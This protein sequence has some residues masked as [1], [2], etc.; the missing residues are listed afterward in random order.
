MKAATAITRVNFRNVLF[1][2]DFSEPSEAAVPFVSAIARAYGSQ[3]L[4]LNVL[5]PDPLLY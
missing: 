3:T 2:T 4:V 1:L 5:L